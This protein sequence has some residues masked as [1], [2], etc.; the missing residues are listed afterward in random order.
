MKTIIKKIACMTTIIS[1]AVIY[2]AVGAIDCNH[3]SAQTILFLVMGFIAFALSVGIIC[4]CEKDM[5][6]PVYCKRKSKSR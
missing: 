4:W 3:C 5:R 1:F 2:G 6:K